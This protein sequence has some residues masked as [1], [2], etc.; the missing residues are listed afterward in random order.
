VCLLPPD[1]FVSGEKKMIAEKS[2]RVIHGANDDLFDFAGATVATVQALLK[3]AFNVPI[4]AFGYINGVL[5]GEDF[6]LRGDDT[7]EFIFPWGTKGASP[8]RQPIKQPFPY[9]GGKAHDAPEVWRRFGDVKNYVEP[10]FGGGGVLLNRPNWEPGNR[11]TV[12][13]IDSLLV[14][15]WKAVKL[16]P[17]K[18]ARVADY[19]VIELDLHARHKWLVEQRETI[20]ERIRTDEAWCDPIVAAWWVWGISQW[21]GGGWCAKCSTQSRKM[22]SS[23][24]RG[25]HRLSHQRPD[26]EGSGIHRRGDENQGEFLREYFRVLSA[27]LRGVRILSGD[28]SRTVT[29]AATFR[30]GLTGVFLDPPYTEESGRKAGLYAED[31]LEVGHQVRDWAVKNGKNPLL[32]IALCGYEGEYRM[33]SSWSVFEWKSQGSRNGQK[34]RIWFSPHCLP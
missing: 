10:F 19:P 22:P 5:V 3:D 21:I 6:V 12:N 26:L 11:E 25:V 8:K 29:P 2:V 7:L 20:R 13:D 17:R 28:W 23:H 32:R 15:F 24:G 16:H 1:L 4:E 33:P 27:R 14:N 9:L 34:E 18:L 30:H 31:D